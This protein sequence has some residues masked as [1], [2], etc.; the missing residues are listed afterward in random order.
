MLYAI[1]PTWGIEVSA[2]VLST[3]EIIPIPAGALLVIM[4]DFLH[5]KRPGLSE[6]RGQ[7]EGRELGGE[8]VG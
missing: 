8:G 5:L 1:I 4:G 6:L 3:L 2:S 7:D